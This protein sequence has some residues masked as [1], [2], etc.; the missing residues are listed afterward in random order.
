[1]ASASH[2]TKIHKIAENEVTYK[3]ILIAGKGTQKGKLHLKNNFFKPKNNNNNNNTHTQT[4]R[5]RK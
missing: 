4:L 3:T 5:L 2:Q 1:M